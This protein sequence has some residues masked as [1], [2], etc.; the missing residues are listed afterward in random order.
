MAEQGL[1]HALAHALAE[2][3]GGAAVL[4]A[5]V[6]ADLDAG[7][8]RSLADEGAKL[9]ADLTVMRVETAQKSLAVLTPEQRSKLE[10]LRAERREGGR[11]R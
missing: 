10:Q 11:R 6:E 3:V 7:R 9:Q 4:G 8:V 5:L 1:E 2:Q